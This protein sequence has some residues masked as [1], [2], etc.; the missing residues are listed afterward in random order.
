M[1]T[2]AMIA[3][4]QGASGLRPCPEESISD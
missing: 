3:A 4:V 2:D 1:G